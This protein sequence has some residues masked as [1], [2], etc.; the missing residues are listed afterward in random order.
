MSMDLA[1]FSSGI[2]R[3]DTEESTRPPPQVSPKRGMRYVD[4]YI[5]VFYYPEEVSQQ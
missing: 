1:S 3:L 5:K 4:M 2:D